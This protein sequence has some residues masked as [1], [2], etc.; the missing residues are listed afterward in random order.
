[1]HFNTKGLVG[2]KFGRLTV[3][4]LSTH[5]GNRGQI[6]WECEC[7]CG[8]KHIVTGESLRSGKSKSCGCLLKESRYVKNRNFDRKE[9][10]IEWEY[11]R[12]KLRQKKK[13]YEGEILSF[14]EFKSLSLSPCFYCGDEGSNT[15]SD[16]RTVNGQH[17]KVT[18]CV[19]KF[20]GIDRVDSKYGY[21]NGNSVSCCKHCNWAK[22][23]FNASEFKEMIRK[24]YKHWACK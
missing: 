22:N 20:N 1:M 9:K 16:V 23:S 13:K 3:V 2:Q 21:T 10:L 12:L 15:V 19:L 6:R 7:E 18:D 8:N 14:A 5:R 4:A 17:Y 11:N 24:I